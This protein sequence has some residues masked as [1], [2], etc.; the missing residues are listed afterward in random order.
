M[1]GPDFHGWTDS[2]ILDAKN[3]YQH[4]VETNSWDVSGRIEK[5]PVEVMSI[6]IMHSTL[7]ILI[8]CTRKYIHLHK[9]LY[10][11]N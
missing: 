5:Y 2:E 6:S 1:E 8:F 4:L 10:Y 11:F 7:T 9:L 3:F